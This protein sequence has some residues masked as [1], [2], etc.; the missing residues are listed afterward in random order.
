MPMAL[1]AIH[2]ALLYAPSMMPT[3]NA[4]TVSDGDW[5]LEAHQ[6]CP[7]AD[8]SPTPMAYRGT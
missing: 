7:S 1:G 5:A 6:P 3:L 4:D 8:P 2:K